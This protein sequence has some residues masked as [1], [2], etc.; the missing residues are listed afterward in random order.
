MAEE[1]RKNSTK[2]GVISDM[3]RH[4]RTLVGADIYRDGGSLE[5][6]FI[7]ANGRTETLW[8]QAASNSPQEHQLVHSVLLVYPNVEREGPPTVIL[9]NSAEE[10]EILTA[11]E[12]FLADASVNIPFAHRTPDEFFLAKLRQMELC[13]PKRTNEA[14]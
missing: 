5:A 9:P 13:I 11:I 2:S 14:N 1:L 8:L 6:N 3:H 7:L 12:L 4:Y 10:K